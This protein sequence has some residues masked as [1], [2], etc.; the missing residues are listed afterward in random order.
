MT[1][2]AGK[3]FL[4]KHFIDK[5][6]IN[7]LLQSSRP[8]QKRRVICKMPNVSYDEQLIEKGNDLYSFFSSDT[9]TSY[10]R[11]ILKTNGALRSMSCW[12]SIYQKGEYIN[13]HKDASGDIQ[14]LLCL[15]NDGFKENGLFCFRIY[16]QEHKIFLNP[17]DLIYFKA[18]D[19]EHYTTPLIS[20]AENNSP[21]RIVAVARQFF[22]Y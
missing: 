8:L 16:D 9:I 14:I 2:F 7:D 21:T 3:V 12:T 19:I 17:G 1:T 5:D 10:S 22:N 20:T 18:T 15:Q 6:T 13:P 11:E 4:F